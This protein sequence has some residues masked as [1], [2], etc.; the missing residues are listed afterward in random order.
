MNTKKLI[1]LDRDG[2][3]NHDSIHYIK[4]PAE[5]QPIPGS[6][7]AIAKLNQ[8]GF[9]VVVATN[10]SGIA[11]GLFS[12]QTLDDIHQKMQMTLATF[13]GKIDN[14]FVCPHRDEDRCSCRKPKAGL[15]QQIEAHYQLSLKETAAFCVGDSLRDLLAAQSIGANRILV[16]T[17]KGEKT[18]QELPNTLKTVPYFSNLSMVVDWILKKNH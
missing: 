11:R 16:L 14:I 5:W 2:V 13:Q 6:L 18:L 1:V 7:E 10:Q 3:I 17:G 12:K 4:S 15:F 8:A 9:K